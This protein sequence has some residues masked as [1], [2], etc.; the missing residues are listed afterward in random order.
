M[1]QPAP[2]HGR[3][4]A[5]LAATALLW[6]SSGLFVKLLDWSPLAILSGRSL[7]AAVVFLAYLL[8]LGLLRVR[9][10]R[11]HV[12]GAL[13]YTFA[14]LLFVTATKLT[15]AANAIFLQYSSPIW[16]IVLATLILRERPQRA[17]WLAMAGIF[18]GLLLF[19]GDNLSFGGWAG[20]LAAI[21]SGVALALMIVATHRQT[22]GTPA[23]TLLLGS[24][25][26]LLIGLPGLSQAHWSL[27]NLAIIL[28]LGACQIGLAFV[29]YSIA[30]PRLPALETTLILTLEPV[31]N[32]LWVFLALGEAPGALAL[33]GGLIV[34]GAIVLRARAAT[35]PPTQPAAP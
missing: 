17:D 24:L 11:W 4:V 14:Q 27:G 8:R 7:I 19:F 20:S 15:T 22:T 16:V 10:T 29:L 30:A 6:S 34:L 1:S 12:L 5:L 13:G 2:S 31:L 32:P 21:G 35:R 9:Y 28:Y 25:I 26:S 3:A 18:S 23:H 33:A